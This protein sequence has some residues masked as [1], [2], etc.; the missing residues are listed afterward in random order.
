MS[1]RS[2]TP[3]LLR[4]HTPSMTSL[5]SA[6]N[7]YTG[8]ITVSVRVKP[9][10]TAES[11]GAWFLDSSRGLISSQEVGEFS[12]DHVFGGET[13]NQ[14]LFLNSVEP[15][16]SQVMSGYNGCVF[17][18]GMTGSGKTYSMQGIAGRDP[19]V[20]P[21]AV[22][23]I[24]NHIAGSVVDASFTVTL[25]YLEIYNEQLQDLL[26]PSTPPESIKLREDKGGI[27]VSGLKEI[28]CPTA[29]HLLEAISNGDALRRTEGTEYNSRSSRSHAV[30]QINVTQRKRSDPSKATQ[31]CLYLCDLAGSER[32]VSQNDRRKEGAYINKSLLTLGT[33]IARLSSAS[34]SAQQASHIP[35]RDSKL[36]RLLQ[37]ALSGAALVSVI[38]T[39]H[40]SGGLEA[41][42][43]LRFAA[44]AK[45]I[46]IQARRNEVDAG[47]SNPALEAKIE[48]QATEI[49][50]L[51]GLLSQQSNI[52]S[53][54]GTGGGGFSQPSIYVAQLEAEN[55]ILHE[56]VEHLTRLC[57]DSRLDEVIGLAIDDGAS[58]ISDRSNTVAS[59]NT[60][61]E[62]RSYIDHL[63]KKVMRLE[64]SKSMSATNSP[65]LSNGG[66]VLKPQA[67]SH[68]Q[69]IIKELQE[70]I[71]ELKESNR[72]KDRMIEAFR[73]VSKQK[74]NLNNNNSQAYARY[75]QQ[76]SPVVLSEQNL[77]STTN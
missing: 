15:L 69:D 8:T 10:K 6:A 35:Y 55:K 46:V 72:D 48:Q 23:Y 77:N 30:I 17:A 19:G 54:G 7:V 28:V 16:V 1:L 25:S 33:V 49:S 59:N 62:Y 37:P 14:S 61:T 3:S 5:H 21:Q 22:N 4:S 60:I 73:A 2:G 71:A 64:V 34:T 31:A 58:T 29:G 12:F 57:D 39:I 45:N 65:D 24:Y 56:R 50:R 18:Y 26:S 20:V 63:E 67:A 47:G 40:P 44:R 27:R 75:Y 52:Y 43:T 38:C 13:N 9:D 66:A 42:S 70:E 36:T 51:R 53:N 76:A 32:A 74:E 68:L 41:I 11:S